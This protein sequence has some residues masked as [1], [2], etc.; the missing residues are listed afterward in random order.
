[1]DN[2]R[3]YNTMIGASIG[4]VILTGLAMLCYPGGTVNNHHSVGYSFLQNF[5]SDLGR[6][7]TFLQQPKL[8]SL[9]FFFLGVLIVSSVSIRFNWALTDDLDGEGKHPI[10]SVLARFFGIAY[11]IAML[12]IACTPYDLFLD[13]HIFIV[14]VCFSLL[15]PLSICYTILI[16]KYQRMPNRYAI[17]F[18]ITAVMLSIYLY[19]L[20]LGP[21]SNENPYLQ[22]VAQKVIVYSLV[23]SLMYL[24]IGAKK[25]ISKD[26]VFE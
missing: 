25:Y 15:I 3:T 18:I 14:R 12:G 11:A 2:T 19:I 9:T 23:F 17:L 22:T 8:L 4:F 10:V 20:I 5:F 26:R 1:M 7:K 6:Y 13:E 16:Y 21:K 24:A